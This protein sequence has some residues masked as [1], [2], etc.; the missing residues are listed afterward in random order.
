MIHS[1]VSSEKLSADLVPDTLS[2]LIKTYYKKGTQVKAINKSLRDCFYQFC[3]QE[4]DMFTGLKFKNSDMNGE[5]IRNFLAAF[6]GGHAR[7]NL[8]HVHSLS[9][10]GGIIAD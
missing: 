10:I 4:G 8:H 3:G 6:G 7:R 5:D 1:V 9:A 2:N